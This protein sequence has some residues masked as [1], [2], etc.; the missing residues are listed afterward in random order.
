MGRV[1]EGQQYLPKAHDG[2]VSVL[3]EDEDL[4]DHQ[5]TILTAPNHKHLKVVDGLKPAQQLSAYGNKSTMA[6]V[7]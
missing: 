6:V 4:G 1:K 3:S 5:F 2:E 7:I